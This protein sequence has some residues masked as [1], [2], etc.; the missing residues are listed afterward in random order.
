MSFLDL[1][2]TYVLTDLRP[3]QEVRALFFHG[4]RPATEDTV[5]ASDSGLPTTVPFKTP[6]G[7]IVD[8]VLYTPQ[9]TPGQVMALYHP[10]LLVPLADTAPGD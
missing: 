9:P 8:Y 4:G 10:P 7:T 5:T 3:G 2:P 6:N 1:A